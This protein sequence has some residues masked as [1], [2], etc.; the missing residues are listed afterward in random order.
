MKEKACPLCSKPVRSD[1]LANKHF[2][3]RD[4]H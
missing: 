2:T 1:A 4:V 3:L